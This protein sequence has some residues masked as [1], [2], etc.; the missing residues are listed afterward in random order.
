MP[1]L[2]TLS[3]IRIPVGDTT[4]GLILS[5]YICDVEKV[6]LIKLS[7]EHTEYNWFE[8]EDASEL[9]KV[10]YPIEFV[11]RIAELK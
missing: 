1:F 2:M 3:N 8:P 4:V 10:K 5:A 7:E 6:D 11:D 9:L